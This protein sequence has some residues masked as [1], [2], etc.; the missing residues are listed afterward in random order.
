MFQGPGERQMLIAWIDATTPAASLRVFGMSLLERQLAA[1]ATLAKEGVRVWDLARVVV[2][3]RGEEAPPLREGLAAGLAVHFERAKGTLTDD[4]GRVLGAGIV[5]AL[6]ADAVLDARLLAAL[7]ASSGSSAALLGEGAGRTAALRL[8]ATAT[9]A[10][11]EARSLREMAEAQLAARSCAPFA[12]GA[13][14]THIV[15]LRRD[16]PIYGFCLA[17]AADVP[18]AERFLF[19]SNYKGSTDFLTRWVFPPLVWVLLRPLARWRV[20][21]NWISG[22]DVLLAIAAVPLFAAGAWLPA[23][24]LA[25]AMAVLDSVDGKLARLTQRTTR[26]GNWLDHGIDLVHPPF[27]YVAWATGLSGGA[28]GSLFELSLWMFGFYAADRALA[29]IFKGRTGRSIHGYEPIDVA[30]R[31]WISRRNVNLGVFTLGL[32]AGVAETVFVAIVAWQAVCLVFHALRVLQVWRATARP[33][34][35]AET[36]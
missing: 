35:V 24:A 27:W 17:G 18:A 26:V 19:W 12:I 7:A 15:G 1:L 9:L 11:S 8:E 23:L 29:P 16:L 20:H 30:M 3:H 34:A 13:L 10:P 2:A 36:A 32:L 22:L 21:P 33:S 4:L 25:Y 31:T 6:S 5:L 14:E 28:A